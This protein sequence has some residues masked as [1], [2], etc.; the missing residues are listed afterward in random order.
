MQK[1]NFLKIEKK[2]IYIKKI[3][4]IILLKVLKQIYYFENKIILLISQP[5]HVF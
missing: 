3:H 2:V 5:S 4:P 1:R